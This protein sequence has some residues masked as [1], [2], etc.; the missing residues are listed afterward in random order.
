MELRIFTEPQQGAATTTSSASPEPPRSSG[1]TPSSGLTTTLVM[2]DHD[3]LP[4]PTDAWVSL[5]G[6]AR[7]TP[8]I[9]LGTLLSPSTFRGPGPLAIIVA[10]VDQMSG[11]RIELGLGAGWYEAE[12]TAY[13]L[14]FPDVGARFDQLEEQLEVV[15]GL[16]A[17]PVGETFSHSGK[18]YSITDSPGLPKPAQ[19]PG[20]PVIM[21]GVGKRR[22]PALAAKYAAEFNVAFRSADEV[23]AAFDRVL[24][25]CDKIGRDRA[26]LVLSVGHVLCVGRDEAELSRRAEAIG[27]D[28]ADLRAADDFVGTPAEVVD[29]IGTY[30]DMGATRIY[31]QTLD[32]SDLDHLQLVADEV[33]PQLP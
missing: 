33:A 17:T 4:G 14:H 1:T 9:R 11:G 32:L 5:A 21:G 30:T 26:S 6:L 24:T 25:A 31:F 12:H 22:T 23:R 2:G 19:L 27:R 15:T 29:R 16:W 20:P 13:G 3:G 8:R 7:E 18:H 10:Q 28:V